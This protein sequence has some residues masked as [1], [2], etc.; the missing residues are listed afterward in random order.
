MS[1]S[2]YVKDENGNMLAIS[3]AGKWLYYD[4]SVQ[5]PEWWGVSNSSIEEF[6]EFFKIHS[7][8]TGWVIIPGVLP[9]QLVWYEDVDNEGNLVELS[10]INILDSSELI[11]LLKEHGINTVFVDND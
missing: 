10:R 4:D 3:T 5:T 6:E 2:I 7:E 11:A 1:I 8:K 9:S